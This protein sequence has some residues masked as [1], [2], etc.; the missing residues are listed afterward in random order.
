MS[1]VYAFFG[2]NRQNHARQVKQ[3]LSLL[4][5]EDLLVRQM[6]HVRIGHPGMGLREMYHHTIPE[7]IGRDAYIRLGMAHGFRLQPLKHPVRTTFADYRAGYEDLVTGRELTDVN[8][9][10]VSDLTYLIWPHGTYYLVSIMDLYSRKILGYSWADNMRGEHSVAALQ[11]ALDQRGLRHYNDQLIHHSD[12]GSQYTA[13][14]YG[15]LLHYHRIRISMCSSVYENLHMERFNGTIKNQYLLRYPVQR[16]QD[17]DAYVKLAI[18]LYNSERRH[19]T[20]GCT[21]DE[22]ER[23]LADP[24]YPRPAIMGPLYTVNRTGKG[25]DPNQLTMNLQF[26]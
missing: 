25:A 1:E 8:Q 15:N 20:L 14:A 21:P 9:V 23:R 17:I 12:H 10:W 13:T 22:F 5:T 24:K 2:T 3:R 11:Q 18:R 26:Q 16:P 19:Q 6:A 4:Q 7:G